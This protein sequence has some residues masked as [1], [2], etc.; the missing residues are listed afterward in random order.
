MPL[1]RSRAQAITKVVPPSV[2]QQ[3]VPNTV[4][5][6]S[7]HASAGGYFIFVEITVCKPDLSQT[8]VE[9]LNWPGYMSLSRA[10][11]HAAGCTDK[12]WDRV[13][14]KNQWSTMTTK[15]EKSNMQPDE[16]S[17]VAQ[18]V[19]KMDPPTGFESRIKMGPQDE[20]YAE[21]EGE[22]R[23][24]KVGNVDARFLGDREGGRQWLLAGRM[25][26]AYV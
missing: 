9:G 17:G 24:N 7:V 22:A 4:W 26:V 21:N 25:Y 1:C 19:C 8:G 3:T 18:H 5:S 16:D 14:K 10:D 2:P 20:R 11:P 6:I 15:R 23:G 12:A 13:E